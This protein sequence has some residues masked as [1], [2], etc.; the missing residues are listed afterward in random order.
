[1]NLYI[2]HIISDCQRIAFWVFILSDGNIVQG[3]FLDDHCQFFYVRVRA[4]LQCF[5]TLVL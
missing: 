1:L 2:S 5:Q 3:E 4:Y